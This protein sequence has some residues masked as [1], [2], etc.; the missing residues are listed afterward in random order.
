MISTRHLHAWRAAWIPLAAGLAEAAW[1]EER[2]DVETV[3][4]EEAITPTRWVNVLLIVWAGAAS[5]WHAYTVDRIDRT[6]PKQRKQ[7]RDDPELWRRLLTLVT[8]KASGI[9]TTTLAEY[10]EVG[11]RF[12]TNLT[13]RAE[14]FARTETV[15]AVGFGQ[16][17]AAARYSGLLKIWQATLDE[18]TRPTH[19]AAHGQRRNIND[20]Y[21]VGGSAL[22]WPADA[23]GP[24]GEVVNCRCWEDYEQPRTAPG[25]APPGG[26]AAPPG[27]PGGSGPAVPP[28]D[29]TLVPD[30]DDLLRRLLIPI[31]GL[32]DLSG[33]DDLIGDILLPF[34]IIDPEDLT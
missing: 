32:P 29:P 4:P 33:A 28:P 34:G 23:G 2:S 8:A 7:L 12:Y 13:P 6:P 17:T 18:A 22:Q 5:P 27:Q 21:T 1:D 3:G 20:P 26:G 15:Q 25:A 31:P 10:A 11:D 16:H 9:V 24:L 14:R 30:L 19:L